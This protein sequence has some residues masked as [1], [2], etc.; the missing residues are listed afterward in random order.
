WL[1][2][3][4]HEG[5]QLPKLFY[6]NWFRKDPESGRFLWPG[7]GENSRVL[8][9]IFDR[10][11]GTAEGTETAV[12]IVP[13]PGELDVSGLDIA[14]EDLEQIVAVDPEAFKAQLPQVREF[15]AKFG[16][17]LPKEISDQLDAFEQRLG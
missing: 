14:A 9:W 17:D 2:I 11:A 1:D 7:F 10:C 16:D 15:L 3:G 13:G 5:A 4:A 8:K 6:V 12:G